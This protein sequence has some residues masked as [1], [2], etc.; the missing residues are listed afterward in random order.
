[1][2]GSDGDWD[3]FIVSR[4][5]CFAEKNNFDPGRCSRLSINAGGAREAAELAER[6]LAIAEGEGLAADDGEPPPGAIQRC[7]LAGFP[8]Q[9]A[10]RLDRGTLR[11]AVVH[12]R[13]GVLA[14]E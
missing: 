14:R 7:V 10:V 6:F 11:C 2:L 5:F 9:V 3:F 1:M 12:G 4:A 8:D 13:R